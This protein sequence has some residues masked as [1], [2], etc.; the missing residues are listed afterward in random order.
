MIRNFPKKIAALRFQYH[1]T[2]LDI[3]NILNQSKKDSR[4]EELAKKHTMASME[5]LTKIF[6]YNSIEEMWER[7]DKKV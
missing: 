7:K 3:Y 6:N 5:C 2:A 1:T 4:A